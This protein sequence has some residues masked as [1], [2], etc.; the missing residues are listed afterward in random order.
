MGKVVK[1]DEEWRTALS[2]QE[3]EIT[4]RAETEQAF[5]GEYCETKTPGMYLC[6]CCGEPLFDS[7][8]KYDSGSGWPSFYEPISSDVVDTQEDRTMFMSRTEVLCTQCDAL[9]GHVFPDGPA[10]TGLRFC[11]NSASLKLDEIE[12]S[13]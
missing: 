5:T 6:R 8:T 4:R 2:P 1:S 12:E 9:L 3:F 10:P 11:L 13:E 7:K